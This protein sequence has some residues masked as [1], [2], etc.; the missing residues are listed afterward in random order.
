MKLQELEFYILSWQTVNRELRT[1]NVQ[2]DMSY[3]PKILAFAGS[4]RKESLNKK[5]VKIAAEGARKAGAIVT[6]IDLKD[7]PLP[8]FDGDLEAAEGLP[9]NAVRLQDLMLEHEGFLISSPEYNSGIPGT[10]KNYIDWTSRPHGDRKAGA[11]YADKYCSLMTASTGGLGG[12]RALPNIRT[13]L[14]SMGVHVLAQDFALAK[15]NEA[16]DENGNP[17]SDFVRQS[18]E[19]LGKNLAEILLKVKG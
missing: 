4:L 3:Q 2:T 12:I 9:E 18:L 8:P 6:Y 11:A 19:N 7:F 10:F 1:V 5:A 16:F 14:A 15:A 13:I 17:K